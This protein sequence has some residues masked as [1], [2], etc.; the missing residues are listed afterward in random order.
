MAGGTYSW[1]CDSE[2]SVGGLVA[3]LTGSRRINVVLLVRKNV[4]VFQ[5]TDKLF[6]GALVVRMNVKQVTFKRQR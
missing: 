6:P 4:N 3:K 2:G 5:G 1:G